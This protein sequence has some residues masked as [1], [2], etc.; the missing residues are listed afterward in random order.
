MKELLTA[1]PRR[2][3][4]RL[5][6]AAAASTMSP[7]ALG[8]QERQA[9]NAARSYEAS[10]GAATFDGV[11]QTA[12]DRFYDPH[13]HGL[14]W[15]AVRQRYVPEA[16][17][18]TSDQELARVINRMLSELQASHTHYYMPSEPEYY[19]LADIFA[20]TLRRGMQSAFPD[21]RI[22]YP[23]IGIL[24]HVDAEVTI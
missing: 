16:L 12:R 3:F 9:A 2:H 24:S 15:S 23:G 22:S 4:F 21:G 14:D 20:G 13:L 5:A 7:I 11:W 10:S 8:A 6:A 18:A 1:L 19:Q 17:K